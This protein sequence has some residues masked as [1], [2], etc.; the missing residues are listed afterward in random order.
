MG[1]FSIMLFISI[2]AYGS[3]GVFVFG[4]S[5]DNFKD[6]F[7]ALLTMMRIIVRD[8]DYFELEAVSPFLGPIFFLTYV[9]LIFVVLLVNHFI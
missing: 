2:A 6:F 8:F 9:I 5:N 4:G 3:L 7:T 1:E